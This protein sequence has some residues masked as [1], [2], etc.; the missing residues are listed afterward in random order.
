MLLFHEYQLWNSVDEETIFPWKKSGK[1]EVIRIYWIQSCFSKGLEIWSDGK[2][3]AKD[4]RDDFPV[5]SLSLVFFSQT[6][7]IRNQTRGK[8]SSLLKISFPD[9]TTS[10]DDTF[11]NKLL[12][13]NLCDVIPSTKINFRP[14]RTSSSSSLDLFQNSLITFFNYFHPS[15]TK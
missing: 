4:R 8:T 1:V 14:S 15:L 2:V 7:L 9:L 10:I 12:T 3:T 13:L 6:I 5:H 11:Q